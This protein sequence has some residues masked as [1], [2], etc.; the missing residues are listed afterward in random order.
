VFLYGAYEDGRAW[1][2][3]ADGEE[4][5]EILPIPDIR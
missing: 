4:W 2:G 5:T 3:P 1:I